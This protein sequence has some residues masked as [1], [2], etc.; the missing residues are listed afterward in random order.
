[1]AQFRCGILL[2][3]I[4]LGRYQNVKDNITGRYRKLKPEERLCA[5][6]NGQYVEDEIHFLCE[7]TTYNDVRNVLYCTVD[8]ES[9]DFLNLC[10]KEKFIY[11]M[12][13]NVRETCEYITKAW[14]IRKSI[15]FTHSRN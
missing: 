7:C 1:M 14:D 5:I 12:T 8:D 9:I 4:E 2:L 6:C 13:H 3:R 11:L 10:S 15:M